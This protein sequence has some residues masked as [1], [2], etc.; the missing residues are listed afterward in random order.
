MTG[1]RVDIRQVVGCQL[2]WDREPTGFAAGGAT[3]WWD[4]GIKDDSKHS[5]LSIRKGGADI[6]E[7]GEE[8]VWWSRGRDRNRVRVLKALKTCLDVYAKKKPHI[9]VYSDVCT[10]VWRWTQ[11]RSEAYINLEIVFKVMRRR[12]HLQSKCSYK[13]EQNLTLSLGHS[14]N[15]NVY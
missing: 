5:G 7:L 12:G 11:D 13:T 9:H 2:C 6:A 1:S 8:K 14:N 15:I 10:C 3:G 4:T